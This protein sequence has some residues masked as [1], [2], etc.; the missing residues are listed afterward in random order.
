LQRWPI[1]TVSFVFVRCWR[2]RASVDRLSIG[3]SGR[4]LFRDRLQSASMVRAGENRRSTI[5]SL[6][7]LGFALNSW[8]AA[9]RASR[10]RDL[11]RQRHVAGRP[12]AD[13]A[14]FPYG[15]RLCEN[16]GPTFFRRIIFRRLN[17]DRMNRSRSDKNP[18]TGK[19]KCLQD[20][21]R[22][23]FYTASVVSG[24]SRSRS[25]R[26][27]RITSGQRWLCRSEDRPWS[28]LVA[29]GPNHNPW[30]R[31]EDSPSRVRREARIR[32]VACGW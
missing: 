3:R 15:W 24:L 32:S 6:T 20:F 2:A 27:C 22:G 7:P 26:S 14:S 8:G 30:R 1:L 28:M 25:A 23:R 10:A 29:F 19:R 21:R 4:G 9:D 16:V 11:V 17:P 12:Q 13:V 18:P 5:G 31:N